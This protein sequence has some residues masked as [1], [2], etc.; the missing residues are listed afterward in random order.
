MPVKSFFPGISATLLALAFAVV[1][2]GQVDV[3]RQTTAITYPI[4]EQVIV[5]FRG[6]TRFPRMKGEAK[7]RRTKKNVTEIDLSVSKMPRPF[8]LGAGYATYVLWAVSPEGQI[9]SLGEVKRRGTFEFDSNVS[10]TTRFQT[11][12]LILTAEPHF[13]V[14]QPSQT[15][16]LE[17][18]SPYTKSGRSLVTTR[19]VQYFGNSSDYFRDARTP[20]IAAIDYERTP[21]SILQAIQAIALARFAGAERDAPEDLEGAEASLKK[22]QEVWKAGKRE[23]EVDVLARQAVSGAVKAE[24]V[25]IFRNDARQR[26]NERTRADQ[27]IR[28]AEDKVAAATAEIESLRAEV[29]REIR[30]RELVE[31]D[32]QNVT[33]QNKEVRNE[34]IQVREENVRLKVDIE[35]ARTRAEKAEKEKEELEARV[36]AAARG[37]QV[38]TGLAYLNSAL[39]KFGAV[40]GDG[41]KVVLTI[42]DALWAGQTSQFSVKGAAQ[43]DEVAKLLA[44]NPGFNIVVESHT[45]DR[46]TAEELGELSQRRADAVAARFSAAGVAASQLEAKGYAATNPL[47]PNSTPAN[48]ARNRR[49]HVFLF[50]APQP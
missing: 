47:A 40:A 41:T 27:E 28:E 30:N 29:A 31:R 14:R 7:I 16:M 15:I 19:G 12:A 22:A 35:L 50:P 24:T 2:Q 39:K 49:V 8:E 13:L 38:K 32:M 17:N 21:S 23:D 6:T 3:A 1:V 9:D 25:A 45:D 36:A 37:E 18:L 26:R 42:G 5:Q 44:A 4:E 34:I 10:V 43:I 20:E 33:Q 48:R 46:G 11:F